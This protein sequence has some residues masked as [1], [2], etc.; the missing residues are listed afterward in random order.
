MS[1]TVRFFSGFV[2]CLSGVV[3]FGVGAE[4]IT[5]A[6][7]SNFAATM[8]DLA[9]RFEVESGQSVQMSTA[10]TGK[11]YA[12]IINGAP[13][14]VLLA[15]DVERPRLLEISGHGVAASRFTY[16]FGS[17][18]LW[19][20]DP[21]LSEIDCRRGLENLGRQR[22]AIAN[23]DTAPYGIAARETLISLG[24]WKR[25]QPHLVVGENIAQALHFVATGNAR[26]GFI[27][28]TQSLDARLPDATCTWSVPTELHRPIEQQ[29]ILLKRAADK[30]TVADFMEF[31]RGSAGRA[32]IAR[33]GYALPD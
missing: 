27:A 2:L 13:F 5:V 3:T 18:V 25:V 31:L 23:P 22:L 1:L 9:A 16:A 29:A 8:Q 30:S 20:R 7:A 26:L 21:A 15:A 24:L 33:H 10:S 4:S 28:A 14:E 12:Q 19:S 6:V 11:L 32:I 17:L